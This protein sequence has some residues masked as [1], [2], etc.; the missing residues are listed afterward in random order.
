MN[1]ALA[2]SEITYSNKSESG[3]QNYFNNVTLSNYNNV[4]K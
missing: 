4:T 3:S 1:L 2:L